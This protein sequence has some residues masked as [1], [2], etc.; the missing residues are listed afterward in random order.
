[1]RT[2]ITSAMAAHGTGPAT[3]TSVTGR[4]RAREPA[5]A[6]VPESGA[7]RGQGPGG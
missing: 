7:A 6:V 3:V 2:V 5:E 1:M 4:M